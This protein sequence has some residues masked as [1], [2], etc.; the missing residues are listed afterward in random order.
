[1]AAEYDLDIDFIEGDAE[2]VTRQDG[3]YDFA[4]SEYGAANWCDPDVWVRE[5]WRLLRPGG[6]LA[7]TAS[8]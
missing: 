3:A 5:T 1:L 6:E 2:V 8:K 7:A 4:V